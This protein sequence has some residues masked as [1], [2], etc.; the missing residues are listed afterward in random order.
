[1]TFPRMKMQWT[2]IGEFGAFVPIDQFWQ[3]IADKNLVVGEWH[4]VAEDKERSK[5]SHNHFFVIVA[6][7][8][9]QLPERYSNMFPGKDN[10]AQLL[11]KYCLIKGGY[12]T[13]SDAIFETPRDAQRAAALIEDRLD[14]DRYTIAVVE[15]CV[16]RKF[17]A[18]SQSRA[19]MGN[20]R[21]QQSKQDV[22]E[23]IAGMIGI[24]VEELC[25]HGKDEAA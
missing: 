14:P 2:D 20:A 15:G 5:R 17:I 3:N 1:M 16:V 7:A 25:A 23:L 19:A 4:W 9:A 6:N 8:W 18:E 11:R 21:F 13:V 12:H 22:L 10:G 24:S